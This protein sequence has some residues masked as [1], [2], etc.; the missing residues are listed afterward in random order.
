MKN[1][2]MP[3][4]LRGC[5]TVKTAASLTGNLQRPSPLDRKKSR[6]ET[7]QSAHSPGRPE[8]VQTQLIRKE[9]AVFDHSRVTRMESSFLLAAGQ[10]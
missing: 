5:L 1:L 3:R 6:S 8:W 10:V 4:L 7:A 2:G 9:A